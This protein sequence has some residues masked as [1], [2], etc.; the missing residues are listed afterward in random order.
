MILKIFFISLMISSFANAYDRE[1]T[2]TDIKVSL[3]KAIINQKEILLEQE[4]IRDNVKE[5]KQEIKKLKNAK[6]LTNKESSHTR[7]MLSPMISTSKISAKK[8]AVTSS[9]FTNIRTKPTT[10]SKVLSIV[11]VCT[12]VMI[13][14][15]KKNIHN[16]LWCKIKKG[17][18]IKK[19]LLSFKKD[20]FIAKKKRS[21]QF[22]EVLGLSR[23]KQWACV[24]DRVLVST[25]L[26]EISKK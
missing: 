25:N 16:S 18:F 21:E 5:L 14:E 10:H 13:K 24:D 23:D 12:E 8:I 11:P 2:A 6:E 3:G 7:I 1:I 19:S 4:F 9:S 20:G 22:I 17:G 26:L 15:C